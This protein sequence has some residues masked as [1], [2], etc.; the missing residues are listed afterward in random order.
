MTATLELRRSAQGPVPMLR[1]DTEDPAEMQRLV[2]AWEATHGPYS[3]VLFECAPGIL[4]APRPVTA[5]VVPRAQPIVLPGDFPRDAVSDIDRDLGGVELVRAEDLPFFAWCLVP[6][7]CATGRREDLWRGVPMRKT[8]V[9][10]IEH[11]GGQR[12][13]GDHP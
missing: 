2:A 6:L 7:C 11:R 4:Y 10:R 13:E 8:G 5:L 1:H 12:A 9:N 3:H